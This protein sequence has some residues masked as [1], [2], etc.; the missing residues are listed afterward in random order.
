MHSPT[1]WAL[2]LLT[3][4][5]VAWTVPSSVKLYHYTD[6][7]ILNSDSL[8]ELEHWS[9]AVGSCTEPR[10]GSKF[11]HNP[12]TGLSIQFL[13]LVWLGKTKVMSAAIIDKIQTFPIL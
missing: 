5:L 6:D 11:Q 12:G 2:S 4:D 10:K 3:E 8:T 7:N 9:S 1:V 13:V